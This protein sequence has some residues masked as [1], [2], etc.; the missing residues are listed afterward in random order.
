ML[1]QVSLHGKRSRLK[2]RSLTGRS[3]RLKRATG[4]SLISYACSGDTASTCFGCRCGWRVFWT[5]SWGKTLSQHLNLILPE[6][7][8]GF[9][10]SLFCSMFSLIVETLSSS[11]STSTSS[12]VTRSPAWR[13]SCTPW[14]ATVS[15][16]WWTRR[17]RKPW[18]VKDSHRSS[19][20]MSLHPSL[21][22]TTVKVSA[23]TGLQVC[24]KVCVGLSHL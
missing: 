5:N 20:T 6:W 9:S 21:V 3:W 12:M 10:S 22:S 8:P 11:G 1:L 7:D 15:S 24:F 18:G 17:W 4:S 2:W 19:S 16:P 14:A 23:S 13:N